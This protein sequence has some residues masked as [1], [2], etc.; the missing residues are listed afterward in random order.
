MQITNTQFEPIPEPPVILNPL[1]EPD[2]KQYKEVM[3]VYSLHFFMVRKGKTIR[4]SPEF[5]SYQRAFIQEWESIE[6]N[7]KQIED[8]CYNYEINLVKIDGKKLV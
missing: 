7:L 3:D 6:R 1:K 4:Q 2:V 8:I 5:E